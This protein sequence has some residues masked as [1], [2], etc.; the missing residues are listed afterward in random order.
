MEYMKKVLFIGLI[1]GACALT[2]CKKDYTCTYENESGED[3]IQYLNKKLN[4]EAEVM[5]DLCENA[6]GIWSIN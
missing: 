4:K 3:D 2:S 5:K 1:I 6:G